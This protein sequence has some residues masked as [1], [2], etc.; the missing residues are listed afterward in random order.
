MFEQALQIY[1]N[2]TEI[3][4]MGRRSTFDVKTEGNGFRITLSSKKSS[5][6]D[7]EHFN[8]V[9]GRYKNLDM[10]LRHQTSQYND[11]KWRDAPNRIYSPAVAAVMR[12][13]RVCFGLY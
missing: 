7:K 4:T 11:P 8:K 2:M 3:P 13:L 10:Q 6:I 5:L 9:L 12:D 1:R